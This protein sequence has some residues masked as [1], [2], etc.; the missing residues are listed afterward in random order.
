MYVNF[1][2][3]AD[4]MFSFMQR[5]LYHQ[6]SRPYRCVAYGISIKLNNSLTAKLKD[7]HCEIPG[8]VLEVVDFVCTFN[9]E[10]ADIPLNI[11]SSNENEGCLGNLIS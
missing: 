3:R 1:F 2:I 9:G 8:C 4:A 6:G 5:N 11:I 10:F 7:F